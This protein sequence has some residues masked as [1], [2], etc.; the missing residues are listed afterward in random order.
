MADYAVHMWLTYSPKSPAAL[1]E[2]EKRF[3][4]TLGTAW[5]D[6][7]VTAANSGA[8]AQAMNDKILADCATDLANDVGSNPSLVAAFSTGG[9]SAGGGGQHEA[10][11]PLNIL[12]THDGGQ[13]LWKF[14]YNSVTYTMQVMSRHYVK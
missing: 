12:V 7:T 6:F 4:A 11:T 10:P 13:D 2:F 14:E 3:T 8:L 1:S 5:W 9:W